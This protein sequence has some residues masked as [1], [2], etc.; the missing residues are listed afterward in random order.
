MLPDRPIQQR[1]GKQPPCH[2]GPV[3]IA[4]L[5]VRPQFGFCPPPQLQQLFFT[6]NRCDGV[7]W[8]GNDPICDQRP[9]FL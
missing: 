5:K 4:N 9:G 7:S 8:T 2:D 6:C 3:K 1:Q